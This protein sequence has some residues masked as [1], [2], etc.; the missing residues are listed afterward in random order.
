[1]IAHCRRLA[2]WHSDTLTCYVTIDKCPNCLQTHSMVVLYVEEE[3]EEMHPFNY[4]NGVIVP[5][6]AMVD[7]ILEHP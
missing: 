6:D 5:C 3:H 2:Y 4:L 7:L 1:M